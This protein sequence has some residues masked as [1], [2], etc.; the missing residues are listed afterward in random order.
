MTS[1]GILLLVIKFWSNSPSIRQS[2]A[3]WVKERPWLAKWVNMIRRG[4]LGSSTDDNSNR[5]TKRGP[6]DTI[7]VPE[8]ITGS[9]QGIKQ[10]Q[11]NQQLISSVLKYWFGQFS[12]DG[13]QKH[14]WM[15]AA[16]SVKRRKQVDQEISER[17]ENLL[18]ELGSPETFGRWSE[19]CQDENQIYGCSGKIAAIIV[20]DQFSRHIHRHHLE[21][22]TPT[23]ILTQK[24]LDSVALRTAELMA[25]VHKQEISCGMIPLPMYIFALMPFR[26]KSTIS[27]VEHVQECVENSASMNQQMESMLARFRK[28][29]NR[30]MAVLQDEARRTGG[31]SQGGTKDQTTDQTFTD[32][33][34]LETFAFD[35]DLQPAVDHPVTKT[36]ANFL[37][38]Q[39]I[40]PGKEKDNSNSTATTVIVSLSGGVDSM[41]I[42]SVL[43]NLVDRC[44]YKLNI[45][46]VHI[47]YA[48]RPESGAEADFVRRYCEKLGVD[49][50]CRRINEVTRG[51]TARDDYERIAREMRYDSYREAIAKGAKD[52]GNNNGI[53]GV[54]LGHHRGDLREN[55]LSNAHK[56][57]GP[58]DLSG[59][60][61]VSKN[62]GVT[63]YR[64]LLPLEKTFILD[65][66]HKFGVPYFKDTTPHWSTRGKLRIK[67]LPLLE[68]IYGEGS[69]NN[70]SNLA[71]ESDECRDLLYES[72]I[73]PFLDAVKRVPMGIILDTAPWKSQPVFF[74]KFVL[75][76]TLHRYVGRLFAKPLLF[77][78]IIIFLT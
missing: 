49:F 5:S 17:F 3:T 48:N 56:G 9:I 78:S 11:E 8:D 24:S 27:S 13:S 64:P 71:I 59:M 29:T 61:A 76:E 58:L 31:K 73:G 50:N 22:G 47:D 52:T 38:E 6:V 54:M 60:T 44:G 12:P 69:M 77:A 30:R 39:G 32:E 4:I 43:K 36:I 1:V 28:A 74:W 53:V 37:N 23:N 20:L 65:Y 63:L 45:I 42:A 10:I 18:L 62:D 2:A 72:M 15:I 16:S 57:C 21:S 55:V 14:L 33:D 34:I 7:S 35:C 40:L 68:E 70:L 19:W 46:A 75:R 26:H 25:E 51:I 67:L 66:S 41:V